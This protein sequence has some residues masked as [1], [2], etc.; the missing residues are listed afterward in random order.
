MIEENNPHIDFTS[1]RDV[2]TSVFKHKYKIVVAF[3]VILAVAVFFA[4]K[5]HQKYEAK[6]VL[7]IK[8]GREFFNR[9]EPGPSGGSSI[10]LDSIAKGEISILTSQD[11]L[12]K[13]VKTVGPATL[14]PELNGMPEGPAQDNAAIELFRRGLTVSILGSSLVDVKFTNGDANVAA[15]TVNTL[16]DAFKDRHLEIFG[17]KSTEF[18]E[19]QKRAFEEKL[20]ASENNLAGYKERNRIFAVQEQN[21]ALMA[22]RA[23]V[24]TSLKEVQSKI[25]EQEQNVALIRSPKYVIEMPPEALTQVASLKQRERDLL[26][27]HTETSK[28]VQIVRGEI[29]DAEDSIKK[30]AERLRQKDIRES[31]R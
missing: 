21:A 31:R 1:V 16:V 6:S 3:F 23:A 9:P 12:S 17:G 19:T 10:P 13:V 7:L 26:E 29:Q 25:S 20:R 22:Q 27:K 5:V 15:R 28:T 8:L 24:D 14:Y 4:S 2:L 30:D 18:L 11:L